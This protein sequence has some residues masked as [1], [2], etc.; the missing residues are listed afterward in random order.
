MDLN[1]ATLIGNITRDP[2]VRTTPSGKSVTTLGVATNRAWTDA[3]G[4]KQTQVEFHSV[5]LWSK[6]A[7]IAGQ[8]LRK[9]SRIYIEGRLQTRE[10]TAQ[11]G[12]KR[13]R[14][15]IVA[16]NMIMLSGGPRGERPTSPASS[17]APVAGAPE[18]VE[19]EVKV[20]DIPF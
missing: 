13:T 18:A 12:A 19:E 6:L 5:V 14:T 8:Y 16:E 9:G 10:W 11:D 4:Q 15:E 7:E 2:E 3:A 17:P 1:R 20:E